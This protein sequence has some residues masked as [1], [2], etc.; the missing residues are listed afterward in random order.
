MTTERLDSAVDFIDY[1]ASLGVSIHVKGESLLIS[2][3]G[4]LRDGDA[5]FI[6]DRKAEL[7]EVLANESTDQVED[8]QPAAAPLID[9]PPPPAKAAPIVPP[10]ATIVVADAAGYT[11]ESMKG[12][13]YMWTWIDAKTWYYVKDYPIPKMKKGKKWT[14]TKH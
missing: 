12:T 5:D 9:A 7:L 13:P 6:R 8:Y 1:L 10:G 3:P 11:D 14:H 4:R 2:P